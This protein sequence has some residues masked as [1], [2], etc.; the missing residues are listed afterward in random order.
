MYELY[1]AD[2]DAVIADGVDAWEA[3]DEAVGRGDAYRRDG[4]L[5]CADC[6]AELEDDAPN[7][8]AEAEMPC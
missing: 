1:C 7:A 6:G 8:G 2:C 4:V 5:Y 3:V